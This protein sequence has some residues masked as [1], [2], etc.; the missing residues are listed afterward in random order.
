MRPRPTRRWTH[1]SARPAPS[2]RRWVL[3]AS[4]STS[5][6]KRLCA[7]FRVATL[8]A[9]GAFERA[10]LAA[11]GAL[12][13]YLEL[14]QKGRLPMLKPPMRE[15]SGGVMRIDAATRRNL[16]LTRSL[17]GGRDGSLLACIDRALTGAGARLLETR[18]SA[19]LTA[20]PAIAARLEAV[21]HVVEDRELRTQLREALARVPE[22]ER[23]LSRLVLDRAGPRDLA[24]IRTG[25]AQ[26]EEIAATLAET[27]GLPALLAE[28]GRR[29][30]GHG[31]L[32]DLLDT[33]LVA[34]PPLM[35]RDGGFVAA[36]H[37]ATLDEARK[38]RDEGRGVIAG[39]QADYAARAGVPA[40]K[41]RH[42]NVLGYFIEVTATH[43]EKMLKPPHSETFIHRQTLANAVRFTT[44]DLA[45]LES[46][47]VNAGARALEL[48][49]RIF[50]ESARRRAGAAGS[51]RR[52]RPRAGGTRHRRGRRRAGRRGALDAT[53][54]RFQPRL[55]HLRRASPGRRA[56]AETDRR[57]LCRQ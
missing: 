33:A 55:R 16:E 45:E 26:A 23:A 13:D 35:A 17:A 32:V 1:R 50:A 57:Q 40:L 31:D 15:A 49:K 12:A 8:D 53:D 51:H 19:P 14:T 29:L 6:E 54:R 18:L 48:E 22:I 43:A 20:P 10:E 37:D 25:L 42:N 21:E 2:P 52:R 28:A 46:K 11:L 5:A 38:L 39:M 30:A 44:V 47:I 34:E 27:A 56:R 41:I 3:P 36:G 7:L 24:A 9:F 4:N